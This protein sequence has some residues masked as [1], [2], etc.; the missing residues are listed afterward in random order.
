MCMSKDI[1]VI[2]NKNLNIFSGRQKVL[3]LSLSPRTCV[4]VDKKCHF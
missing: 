4:S 2:W 3:K 1:V